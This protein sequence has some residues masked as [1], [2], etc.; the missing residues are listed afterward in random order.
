LGARRDAHLLQR[1]HLDLAD[2]LA[3]VAVLG[4]QFV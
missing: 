2:A 1:R 4:R 3:P